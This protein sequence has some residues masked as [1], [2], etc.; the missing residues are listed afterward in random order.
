MKESSP[1]S[2]ASPILNLIPKHKVAKSVQISEN[3]VLKEYVVDDKKEFNKLLTSL[4][5]DKDI[6]QSFPSRDDL[7]E[8]IDYQ[9]S[10]IIGF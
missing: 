5:N 2:E 1:K 6:E 7:F 10:Y 4:T 3:F 8:L 9:D